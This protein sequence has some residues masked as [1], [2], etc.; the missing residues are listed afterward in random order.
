MRVVVGR[1]GKAHGIRGQVTIEV[2]TDEPELRFAPGATLFIADSPTVLT[3]GDVRS[4]PR[5]LVVG[6]VGYDDRNQAETLRGA[7]LEVDRP[8]G[9]MPTGEGEFFDSDLIGLA[10]RDS[11]Q[12]TL[13]RVDDVV[14]LPGQDL[15]S[16]EPVVNDA[17][18]TPSWLLP[19]IERFV[20][21]VNLAEGWLRVDPPPGID[22]QE[23]LEG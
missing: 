11:Q 22:V 5:G 21:E 20:P 3:V 19:F 2:R 8:A 23:S 15:L 10:V 12:V 18:V 9:Q 4:G 6:F 16:I 17:G 1:I 13:G 7:I 14:H